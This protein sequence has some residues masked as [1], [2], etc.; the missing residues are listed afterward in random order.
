MERIIRFKI[1][2]VLLTTFSVGMGTEVVFAENINQNSLAYGENVG[3][4]NF[5]PTKGPGVTVTNTVV[6]GFAWGENI[7]WLDLNPTNGGV[8]NNGAG[9]LSG[10][11]W[12]ENIGWINFD[13]T[14]GGVTIDPVTGIFSGYAWGENVGWINFAPPGGGV[15]TSW[16]AN[17]LTGNNISVSLGIGT[18]VTFSNVSSSGETTVTESSTGPTPPVGFQAGNPPTYYDVSTTA[19]YV[20]PVTVCF[21]YDP[22]QYSDPTTLRLLHY[23]NNVWIDVTTSTDIVDHII[24]GQVDSFSIFLIAM[25]SQSDLIMTNVT[26]N[27]STVNQ[28]GT[29]LVTD[30]VVNQG[31]VSSGSFRIAYHLS[32]D[33]IY[34]NGD[35]VTI[36]TIRIVTRLFAAGA[37][38]TATTSL[39][40]PRAMPGGA[41]Y[42]CAMAD[43]L[44]Q[45]TESNETNNALCSTIQ[46]AVPLPDLLISQISTTA[47][48]LSRVRSFVRLVFT[49]TNQGGSRA[50]RFVTNFHLSTDATYGGGDDIAMGRPISMPPLREGANFTRPFLLMVPHA[51]PPGTYYV[52]AMADSEAAVPESDETNNTNCTGTT[53]TVP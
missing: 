13:P 50:G 21:P 53:I 17:T 33:T 27:A 35:D 8:V 18:T 45:V 23:E 4:I 14:W 2:F 41:Y 30:T 11:A 38:S 19:T 28:G 16:R 29:L 6:T 37:T 5:N 43:S 52:C 44:N 51:T 12:G 36:R 25:A 32:T 20:G 46:V 3:W 9:H 34:G 26:P 47:T 22:V 24:C 15:T 39:A 7:G 42:L 40:I 1:A 48:R 31:P 49:M 10:Y